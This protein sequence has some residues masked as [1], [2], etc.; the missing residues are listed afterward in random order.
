[1]QQW[2][3]VRRLELLSLYLP[4]HVKT[5]APLFLHFNFQGNQTISSD[6]DILPSPYSDRPR[7]NQA[8]RWPVEKI[9]DTGY[10]LATVHYFDFF[11]DSKEGYAESILALF[12]Y[13]SE[14]DIPA[15]GGQVA[16]MNVS[17]W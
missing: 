16:E 5:K 12:G 8:S 4:N 11:P 17:Q 13:P 6:P 2:E 15:D 1:M 14:A 7:G 10:G 9:I 3:Q